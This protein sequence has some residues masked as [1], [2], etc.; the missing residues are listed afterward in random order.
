MCLLKLS[1]V[2]AKAD[3]YLIPADIW[4]QGDETGGPPSKLQDSQLE[5]YV[6]QHLYFFV[7]QTYLETRIVEQNYEALFF[8][9]RDM[10]RR[11]L[12]IR[13]GETPPVSVDFEHK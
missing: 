8:L 13:I 11:W 5:D 6:K 4:Y 9:G 1:S 10:R 3:V 2:P 7:G 12:D